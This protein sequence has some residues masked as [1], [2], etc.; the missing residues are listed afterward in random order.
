MVPVDLE[1]QAVADALA[2]APYDRDARAF[3]SWLGTICYLTRGAIAATLASLASVCAP[4]SG[5]AFDYFQPTSTM[6]PADLELLETLD[7]GGTRRGEPM[8][9]LLGPEEVAAML[10]TAGL[11]GVEDLSA[12]EIRARY[13]RSGIFPCTIGEHLSFLV[14][15]GLGGDPRVQAAFAFLIEDMSAGDALDCGRFQHRDCRWGAIAALNGLAALPRGMRSAQSGRVVERLADALLDA[16]YD[17]AGEHKRSLTF[18]VPRAW[19]LL[20]ALKALAA[21]GYAQDARF[22]PLLRQV[23]DRQDSQGRWLCGSV[24]RT[25]PIEQ[26]NRPSKWVTLGALRVLKQAAWNSGG[27]RWPDTSS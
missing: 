24:S 22:A 4:G 12:S 7:E 13:L 19:D 14:Y 21:H 5:L 23:L 6:A 10:Q 15:F 9:T 3:V 26:R 16:E 18:A 17:L 20:S 25:W 11:R 2:A 8:R 27:N 1:R